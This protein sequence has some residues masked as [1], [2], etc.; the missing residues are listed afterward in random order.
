MFRRKMGSSTPDSNDTLI[1]IRQDGDIIIDEQVI[2]ETGG[3]LRSRRHK[4][5]YVRNKDIPL[6]HFI[7]PASPPRP[8]ARAFV[9]TIIALSLIHIPSPRD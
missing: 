8:T 2:Q 9:F 7:D 4:A 3:L 6:L 5:T 1:V